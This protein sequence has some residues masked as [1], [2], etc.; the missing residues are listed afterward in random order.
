MASLNKVMIIGNC[1]KDPEVRFTAAG[2]AVTSFGVATT[3]KFKGK[4]GEWEER[5]EFH[6]VTLFGKLA[7]IA[8]EYLK[9]GKMVYIEGR[10]QT[11]KWQDKEGTDRYTTE[12]IGDKMQMLGAKTA[13]PD[14]Q[15]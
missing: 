7:E 9:K 12:I 5:T 11:R 6:N 1:T 14:N 10:L 8:G 15:E 3:E 13:A 2:Q 4:T